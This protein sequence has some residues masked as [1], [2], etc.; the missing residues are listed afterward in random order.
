MRK[1]QVKNPVDALL[2]LTDC[3]LAT[4][5]H[6]AMMKSRSKSEYKRQIS[7]AQFA[8]DSIL[9]FYLAPQGTR[10]LD[11]I[12]GFAGDVEAWALVTEVRYAKA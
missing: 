3:T 12:E 7:M 9:E 5:E 4:V 11:V 10:A 2:Y 1:D 8:V 6:M